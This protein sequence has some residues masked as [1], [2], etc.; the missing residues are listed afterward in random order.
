[1]R[2]S[3]APATRVWARTFAT[4]LA[5]TSASTS[6]TAKVTRYS[7]LLTANVK[8]GGTKQKSRAMTLAT[9][10]KLAGPRPSRSAATV[11]PEQVHHH[12]I[13]Q[14]EIRVHDRRGGRAAAADGERRPVA[15]PF[16]LARR[17]H[18]VAS[19]RIRATRV[20]AA[21]DHGDVEAAAAAHEL[22][23]GRAPQPRAPAR[24]LRLAVTMRVTLRRRAYSSSASAADAP[25]MVTVSA[26]SDSASRSTSMRRLRSL[27]RA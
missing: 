9:A 26:P 1:V 4:R 6:M 23:G 18:H 2:R 15:L 10:A 25:S 27:R 17:A 13:G 12:E 16:D 5:M 22:G 11:A 20:L 3:R 14:R 21:R 8:R 24:A 19:A 7:R